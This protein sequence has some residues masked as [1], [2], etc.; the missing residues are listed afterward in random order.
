MKTPVSYLVWNVLRLQ[1]GRLRMDI[2]R[3]LSESERIECLALRKLCHS[4][5]IA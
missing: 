3:N 5:K 2:F 1:Y 4:I